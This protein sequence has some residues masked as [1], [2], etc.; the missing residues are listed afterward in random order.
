VAAERELLNGLSYDLHVKLEEFNSW[1]RLLD[2]LG[3][4]Q[5]ETLASFSK[6]KRSIRDSGSSPP[7]PATSMPSPVISRPQPQVRPAYSGASFRYPSI[8]ISASDPCSSSNPRKRTWDALESGQLLPPAKRVVMPVRT[9]QPRAD[10]HAPPQ[11]MPDFH[12]MAYL[13]GGRPSP[14]P[15]VPPQVSPGRCFPPNLNF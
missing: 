1:R 7:R 3:H 14:L 9:H 2:G 4:A 10:S 11:P 8:P 13:A 6:R 12:D 15:L 5:K